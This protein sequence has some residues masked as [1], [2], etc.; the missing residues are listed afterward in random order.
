[1]NANAATGVLMTKQELDRAHE[2]CQQAG[3]WLVVD[4]TYEH[5]TYDGREHA[6]VSGPHVINIFSM[7]KVHCDSRPGIVCRAAAYTHILTE[8]FEIRHGFSCFCTN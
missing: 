5:F 3:V 8:V 7:S 4:N 1:M 6:C 2:L